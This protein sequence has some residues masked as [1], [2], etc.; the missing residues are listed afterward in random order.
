MTYFVYITL[1][2]LMLVALVGTWLSILPFVAVLVAI[3]YAA[4]WLFG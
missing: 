2:L 4:T 1:P 3:I